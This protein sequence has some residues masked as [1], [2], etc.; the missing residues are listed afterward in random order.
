MNVAAKC[1]FPRVSFNMRPNIS[2]NQYEVA[3]K[4]PNTAATPMIRWK[5]ATTK[6]VSCRY[7][8]STG[9]PRNIPLSP[10]VTKMETNPSAN[11]IAVVNSMWP[12]HNVPS[13][14]NVLTADGTP[15]VIVRTEKAM[16][17]Y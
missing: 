13:Q 16:E 3:A 6:Y 9:C 1:T 5:W 15:I 7:K 12:P 2:G 4:I 14:L 17:E 11:N 8:S 10:P